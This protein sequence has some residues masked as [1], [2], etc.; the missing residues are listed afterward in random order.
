MAILPDIVVMLKVRDLRLDPE[1][2]ISFMD[3]HNLTTTAFYPATT[4]CK[5][6]LD[7]PAEKQGR[8]ERTSP[9]RRA[10]MTGRS[11]F[12]FAGDVKVDVIRAY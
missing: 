2:T 9:A 1:Q 12:T 11:I 5:Y 4:S 3:R 6:N 7:S 8:N 10:A